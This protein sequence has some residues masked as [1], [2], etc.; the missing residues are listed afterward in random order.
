MPPVSTKGETEHAQQPS[1][2]PR[3]QQ[4]AKSLPHQEWQ[5]VLGIRSINHAVRMPQKTEGRKQQKPTRNK[6]DVL[7]SSRQQCLIDLAGF[8]SEYVRSSAGHL[9]STHSCNGH[10]TWTSRWGK[11]RDFGS[12]CFLKTKN[13][14]DE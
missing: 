8:S 12:T 7:G 9:R 11:S 2:Q 5:A 3:C 6:I 1:L 13:R 4:R 14:V 10:I